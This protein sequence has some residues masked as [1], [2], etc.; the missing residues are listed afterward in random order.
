MQLR[1]LAIWKAIST[2]YLVLLEGCSSSQNLHSKFVLISILVFFTVSGYVTA[3]MRVCC[4]QDAYWE[5][6]YR[7]SWL[8]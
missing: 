2:T 6:N 5:V 3:E 8:I 4:V 7:F 1:L